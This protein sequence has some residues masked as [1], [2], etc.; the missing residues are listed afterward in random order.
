VGGAKI[1]FGNIAMRVLVT[2]LQNKRDFSDFFLKN[3]KKTFLGL[4]DFQ[5]DI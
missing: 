2:V 3:P 4:C 1:R 5:S